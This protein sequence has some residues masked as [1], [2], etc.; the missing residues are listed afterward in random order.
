MNI[1]STRRRVSAD[2]S[3][4]AGKDRSKSLIN[5]VGTKAII[6]DRM[7]ILVNGALESLRCFYRKDLCFKKTVTIFECFIKYPKLGSGRGLSYGYKIM[8]ND[9]VTILKGYQLVI[10]TRHVNRSP[11]QTK[12]YLYVININI[13]WLE[14]LPPMIGQEEW[15]ITSTMSFPSLLFER[16]R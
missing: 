13:Y 1:L 14:V 6:A 4:W 9:V 7:L 16:Q 11:C 10:H 12:K 15:G 3:W 5:N 8:A 2:Q